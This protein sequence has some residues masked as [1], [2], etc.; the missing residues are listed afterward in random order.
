VRRRSA[1]PGAYQHH[2]PVG[3]RH[4]RHADVSEEEAL[5]GHESARTEHGHLGL[6]RRLQQCVLGIV[7]DQAADDGQARVALLELGPCL[8]HDPPR[9]VVLVHLGGDVGRLRQQQRPRVQQT[10]REPAAL[11]FLG[12][13]AG[14]GKALG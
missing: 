2:R 8:V 10:Q 9:P 5:D 11:G 7:G 4:D 14:G 6:R 1:R 12:G 13:P 3:P